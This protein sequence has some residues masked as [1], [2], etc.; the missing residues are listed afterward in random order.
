MFESPFN[1]TIYIYIYIVIRNNSSPSIG[2]LQKTNVIYK[3]KCPLGDCISDNNN[4]YVG[5]TSTTL[6]RRLTMHLSDTSSIAQHLKK[7]S[8]PTA[9]LR[10]ILTDNTTIL[11]HQNNKQKLQILEALHIRNLQ[12]TLNI[13]I[14][15]YIYIYIS[16]VWVTFS[17]I[18]YIQVR[19]LLLNQRL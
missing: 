11:E 14:Y 9:Q 12:P 3:F 2:V 16:F 5:L 10:K 19:L 1:C 6:S 17:F 8:C 18:I 13:Y 4:I 15:I 7:H